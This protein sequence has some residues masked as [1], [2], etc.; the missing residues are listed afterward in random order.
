MI[1]S[2]YMISNF[3]CL[4]RLIFAP[5]K[6]I[7]MNGSPI[8]DACRR[9]DLEE[10][11]ALYKEDPQVINA[12]DMKGFT[13]LILAV[14]NDQPAVVEFL[15]DKGAL[16]DSGDGAGNTALMGVC[17]KGYQNIA[18][19]LIEA[20]ADVNAR[21]A[22]GATA[23]T[24]ASTFGHLGIAEMLLQKGADQ[25]LA[26]SRGKTPLDHARIQENEPM[27]ALLKRYA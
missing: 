15:L 4:A 27:M 26:D 6:H 12:V 16:L 2:S 10:V 19:K 25:S 14:Y 23:L 18:V 3:T 8:F 13:P 22:N 9:G 11:Q 5:D 24:F 17:F 7:A 21:N 20:G 1:I